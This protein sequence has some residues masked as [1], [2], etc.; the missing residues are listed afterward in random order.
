M[1]TQETQEVAV[2]KKTL[3][4]KIGVGAVL[5]AAVVA[6]LVAFAPHGD[7]QTRVFPG[8]DVSQTGASSSVG[9]SVRDLTL[10][11]VEKTKLNQLAGA[12]VTS[13][14]DGGPAARAG[15]RTGDVV[16]EFDGE[17]V[18]SARHLTRL[19]RETPPDR[20]VKTAIQRDG[21]RQTIDITPEERNVSITIPDVGPEIERRLRDLPERFSFEF[22]P[23]EIRGSIGRSGRL[24]LGA[25]L[26]RLDDQLATYFGV[27][28]GALV[29]SVETDS[30]AARAGLKAGDV[31]TAINGRIV[32]A[33]ADVT[34]QLRAAEPNSMLDISIVREKKEM[35]LKATMP[36]RSRPRPRVLENRR[37][38]EI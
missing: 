5:V 17:R 7:A 2:S 10:A 19:V 28:N 16:T 9:M 14:V 23:D 34:E 35:T 15:I 4:K 13:V 36:E 30:P 32:D 6:A 38:R 12:L 21:S 18:R 25:S 27:K 26:I 22:D 8:P 3:R 37:T 31:I 29:A 11:D 24:R 33:I 20:A 1:E